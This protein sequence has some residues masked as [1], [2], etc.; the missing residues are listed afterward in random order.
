MITNDESL[1][2]VI[3]QHW[4]GPFRDDDIR[5][6]F[7]RQ[8]ALVERATR[9]GAYLCTLVGD[10]DAVDARQRRLMGELTDNQTPEAL[11]R[12]VT[13]VVVASSMVVRGAL[14]AIKW[15]MKMPVEAASSPEEAVAHAVK[16]YEARRLTVPAALRDGRA[17]A[18][19]RTF[20]VKQA[21]AS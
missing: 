21:A 11:E 8:S 18:R 15:F 4:R 5:A 20:N 14:T 2:P 7:A 16:A 19:L 12:S 3:V 9:E 1:F 6:V 13:S 10:G 17:L